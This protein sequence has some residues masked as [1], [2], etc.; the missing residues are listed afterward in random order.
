MSSSPE[1]KSRRLRYVVVFLVVAAVLGLYGFKRSRALPVRAM[2]VVRGQAVEAVYATG[3]VEA[4]N[5]VE[6]KAQIAGT[7]A[8]LSVREGARVKKGDLI[9]RINNPTATYD[10]Q[11]GNSDL[12]AAHQLAAQDS[13]QLAALEAQARSIRAELSSA[14]VDWTRSEKL[15]AS[16]GVPQADVDRIAAKVE[17]LLGSL[18]AN[19]AQQRALRID[20]VANVARQAAQVQSY[21]ARVSDSEVRAPL[22]GVVLVRR[23]ELGE[24]VSVNQPL[25]LVG[26]T[27][28]LILEVS[29]DEAD[30]ARIS[31]GLDGRVKTP[32]AVTL[33]AFPKQVFR[34]QVFEIFPDADRDKK[35][36]LVKVRF[37]ALPAGLRSG[38][39]A[40]V[41]MITNR[42]AGLLAPASAETDQEVWLAKG[43]LALKRKV[44]VGIRDPLRV[45]ILEGLSE[46]DLV[47]VEGRDQLREGA[48]L[49]VTE[50]APD[51]FEPMPD[52][53]QPAR[54]SL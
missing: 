8:E 1:T 23:V 3:S 51:K 36:F 7:I 18:D 49:R 19:A 41:N 33:L 43:E 24:V 14:R 47:I 53:T 48:R 2:P 22:D 16:G 11:R 46:G 20:L 44:K 31:D 15:R 6:V 37:D 9:A 39:T 10:L 34:G 4:E 27:R 40:E 5:R 42:R 50:S 12:S 25:F 30:V 38:M 35:A 45:E 32:V 52:T 28:S 26:D 13:P 29:V 21:A 54:T 17:Q